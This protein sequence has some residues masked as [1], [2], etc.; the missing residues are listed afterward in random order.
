MTNQEIGFSTDLLWNTLWESTND[1]LI[2]VNPDG[3]RTDHLQPMTLFRHAR[4][5]VKSLL[6]NEGL[7]GT[8]PDR[9]D[10]I[11]KLQVIHYAMQKERFSEPL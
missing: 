2:V 8:P 5:V 3:S 7:S 9:K 4:C 1:G 10:S 11:L 6:Q